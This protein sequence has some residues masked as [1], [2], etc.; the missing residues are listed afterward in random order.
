MRPGIAGVLALA[1]VLAACTDDI[2]SGPTDSGGAFE[3]SVSGGT[4]PVYSWS[5]GAAFTVAVVRAA[6]RTVVVWRVADPI[7]SDIRSPLSHGTVPS[8]AF[9]TVS[10]ERTLSRGIRYRVTITLADG[11][12][13]FREFTP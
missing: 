8:G 9:E 12:S 7:N 1:A 6:D 2:F 5:A 10:R 13:A 4:Q 3:I 11:R